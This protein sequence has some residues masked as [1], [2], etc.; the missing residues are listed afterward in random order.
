MIRISA[1]RPSI[2]AC[3]KSGMSTNR[4][5]LN[6]LNQMK[7]IKLSWPNSNKISSQRM[8]I[9]RMVTMKEAKMQI[10]LGLH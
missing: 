4:Y 10:E 2:R 6:N 5:S 7:I 8:A 1:M 3:S 9:L